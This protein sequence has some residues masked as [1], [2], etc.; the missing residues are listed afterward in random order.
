MTNGLGALGAKQNTAIVHEF[1]S[2]VLNDRSTS[3]I[4]LVMSQRYRDFDPIIIPGYLMPRKPSLGTIRDVETWVKY[5]DRPKMDLFFTVEE[6][7][8]VGDSVAVRMFGEGTVMKWRPEEAWRSNP[9]RETPSGHASELVS[10]LEGEPAKLSQIIMQ[11][12][13]MDTTQVMHISD[14]RIVEK[15]GAWRIRTVDI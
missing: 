1:V 9:P 11:H 12:L 5:L 15:W 3:H 4:A 6:A 2:R 10:T 7:F 14:G 8:E 13:M